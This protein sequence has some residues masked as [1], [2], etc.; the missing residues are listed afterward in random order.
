METKSEQI[1]F[2]VASE[3]CAGQI[4]SIDM[5]KF[6]NIVTL[7]TISERQFKC[8]KVIPQVKAITWK[9]PEFSA[10]EECLRNTIY[11][12]ENT[13]ATVGETINETINALVKDSAKD[14][15]K[16]TDTQQQIIDNIVNDPFVSYDTLADTLAINRATVMRNIQFLKKAEV[17]TRIGSRK[18]GYWQI[19]EKERG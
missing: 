9:E 19:N 5:N 10:D 15:V 16:L 6:T 3:L 17:I 12:D 4:K 7:Q 2:R 8:I 14:P 13:I 18:T 1:D 11:K